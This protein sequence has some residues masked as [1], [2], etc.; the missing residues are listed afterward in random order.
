[1]S[2]DT[3]STKAEQYRSPNHTTCDVKVKVEE[4][5]KVKVESQFQGAKMKLADLPTATEKLNLGKNQMAKRLFNSE[6]N[7]V[8]DWI[9]EHHLKK[10]SNKRYKNQKKPL[11]FVFQ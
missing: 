5:N 1:M 11:T 6:L 8:S 4:D 3:I 10:L 9:L 7:I 2:E